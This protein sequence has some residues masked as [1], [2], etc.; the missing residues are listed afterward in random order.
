MNK[1]DKSMAV[2]PMLF[3][4]LMTWGTVEC[5][6]AVSRT[7]M[8]GFEWLLVIPYGAWVMAH[9]IAVVVLLVRLVNKFRGRLKGDK[10]VAKCEN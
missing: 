9:A 5:V 3:Y 2:I 1:M 7:E 8:V 4:G 10:G 6:I